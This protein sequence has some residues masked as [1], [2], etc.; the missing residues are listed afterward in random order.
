MVSFSREKASASSA[1]VDCAGAVNKCLTSRVDA[2]SRA[3]CRAKSTRCERLDGIS[4]PVM[5]A[6]RK[7]P[8]MSSSWTWV[9]APSLRSTYVDTSSTRS[10][11]DWRRPDRLASRLLER[12]RLSSAL[13][14]AAPAWKRRSS[15][16]SLLMKSG[17]LRQRSGSTSA[18]SVMRVRMRRRNARCT[19][20]AALY[21]RSSSASLV[22]S[23]RRSPSSATETCTPATN[24]ID[25]RL[26]PFGS[27]RDRPLRM[28]RRFAGAAAPAPPAA[29][30]AW[31]EARMRVTARLRPRSSRASRARMDARP[32]LRGSTRGS[33][34]PSL[35]SCS[36]RSGL[37]SKCMP[38]RPRIRSS[39]MMKEAMWWT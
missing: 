28:G 13:S 2:P 1:T 6:H 16:N 29:A 36:S 37:S 3:C 30:G 24:A 33:S 21:V 8:T 27:L 26:P 12:R 4:R 7:K 15:T 25:A 39:F 11:T 14:A 17:S 35:S 34:T 31:D 22:A 9:A 10:A 19:N 32:S 5:V 18:A 38:S 20:S 23:R